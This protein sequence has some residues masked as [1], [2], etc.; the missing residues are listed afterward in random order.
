[1]PLYDYQCDACGHR[2]EE[3]RK[4]S[5]P[6]I[7]K[8]PSCGA[9]AVRKLVSSPAFQFKGTGWY[10]TDY[11]KKSEGKPG[12]EKD[13]DKDAPAAKDSDTKET[14]SGED[15]KASKTSDSS[16]SSQSSSTGTSGSSGSSTKSE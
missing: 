15:A 16:S 5:D 1:M 4:F 10:V 12:K 6:P 3:I 11:A 9:H 13:K 7:E 2:F 8:C 14:K